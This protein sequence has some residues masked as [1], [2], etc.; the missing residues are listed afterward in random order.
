MLV[1]S[2]GERDGVH[3]PAGRELNTSFVSLWIEA[4]KKGAGL[5]RKQQQ[6][7]EEEAVIIRERKGKRQR[8]IGF[9]RGFLVRTLAG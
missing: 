1:H 9:E 4:K 3:S 8:E 6:Q 5:E 7:E 2:V